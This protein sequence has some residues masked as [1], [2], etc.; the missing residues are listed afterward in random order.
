M[1]CVFEFKLYLMLFCII[2]YKEIC[3]LG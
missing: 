2:C 1:M 3:F